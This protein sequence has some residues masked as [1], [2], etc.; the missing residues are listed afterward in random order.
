MIAQICNLCQLTVADKTKT[1][2]N[3]NIVVFLFRFVLV[4]YNC[5]HRLQICDF[6][7][8]VKSFEIYKSAPSG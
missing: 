2:T 6:F 5:E 1:T 3:K 8:E 4:A 7:L